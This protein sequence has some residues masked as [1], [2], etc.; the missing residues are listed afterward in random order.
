[1]L[2]TSKIDIKRHGIY[3]A[4]KIKENRE[5]LSVKSAGKLLQILRDDLLDANNIVYTSSAKKIY[6]TPASTAMRSIALKFILEFGVK[7]DEG[8]LLAPN[9]YS[10]EGLIQFSAK[11]HTVTGF[12]SCRRMVEKMLTKHLFVYEL[13]KAKALLSENPWLQSDPQRNLINNFIIRVE[14]KARQQKQEAIHAVMAQ[15]SM[16]E[17]FMGGSEKH[18]ISA[19]ERFITG[20]YKNNKTQLRVVNAGL[21]IKRRVKG[22]DLGCRDIYFLKYQIEEILEGNTG[23]DLLRKQ[24][25]LWEKLNDLN[26]KDASKYSK[27]TK[28]TLYYSGENDV[29]DWYTEEECLENNYP[30]RKPVIRQIPAEQTYKDEVDKLL[31]RYNDEYYDRTHGFE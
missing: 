28:I 18:F 26:G 6:A 27:G 9:I 24:L 13:N 4:L 29:F 10:Y 23:L 7:D 12:S 14:N 31:V 1:M 3:D 15:M 25:N 21:N 20:E 11:L 5:R 16:M 8:R 19:V 2:P 22:L 17:M 30:L